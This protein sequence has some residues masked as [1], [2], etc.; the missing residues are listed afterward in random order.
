M[1][2][3]TPQCP[4]PRDATSG[5]GNIQGSGTP[6]DTGVSG[7]LGDTAGSGMLGDTG[8]ADVQQ[9]REGIRSPNKAP[10]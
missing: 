10:N 6:G 5:A 1:W 2:G 9:L 8:P 7:M 4:C 3:P